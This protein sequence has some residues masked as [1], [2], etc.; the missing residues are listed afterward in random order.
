[1]DEKLKNGTDK[2]PN[3]DYEVLVIG[4]PIRINI[5]SLTDTSNIVVYTDIQNIPKNDD[6]SNWW[7]Q[8]HLRPFE[9]IKKYETPDTAW[10]KMKRSHIYKYI[11]TEEDVEK[12][13]V[14][15]GEKISHILELLTEEKTIQ[16]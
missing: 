7:P 12:W 13:K 6:Y 8:I 10:E 11:S 3:T 15:L 2:D 1:M 14:K 9:K 5:N 4:T 16:K